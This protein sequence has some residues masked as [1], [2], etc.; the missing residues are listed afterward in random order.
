M[1]SVFGKI[2]RLSRTPWKPIALGLIQGTKESDPLFNRR[3]WLICYDRLH[4]FSSIHGTIL[5]NLRQTLATK[6]KLE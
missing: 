5:R 2:L 1:K 6:N 3:L 4:K